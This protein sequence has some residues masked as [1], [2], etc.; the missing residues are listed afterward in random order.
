MW[1]VEYNRN[2]GFLSSLS[3]DVPTSLSHACACDITQVMVVIKL[4][5]FAGASRDIPGPVLQFTSH[6]CSWRCAAW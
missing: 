3:G 1:E 2:E 6:G 5:S 4:F